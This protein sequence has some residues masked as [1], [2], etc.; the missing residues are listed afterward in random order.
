MAAALTF[1]L[2]Q[3]HR[4]GC[5]VSRFTAICLRVAA[6]VRCHGGSVLARKCID[7]GVAVAMVAH[8]LL[9]RGG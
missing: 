4:L 5:I 8:S 7:D 2:L 6:M 3:V 1:L 9:L